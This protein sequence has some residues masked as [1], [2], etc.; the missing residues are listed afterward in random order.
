MHKIDND[1]N[2]IASIYQCRRR[3]LNSAGASISAASY[4]TSYINHHGH[5][6]HVHININIT[7]CS[8]GGCIIYINNVNVNPTLL[9]IGTNTA[10]L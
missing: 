2:I 7:S 3:H 4:R 1:V 5:Q 9:N 10:L 8:R 6:Y